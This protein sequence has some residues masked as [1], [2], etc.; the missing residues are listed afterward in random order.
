M[1]LNLARYCDL[2]QLRANDSI[3]FGELF[4]FGNKLNQ[5]MNTLTSRRV[6]LYIR[7]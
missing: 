7:N 4:V 5:Q 3:R 6:L 2:Y 1:L